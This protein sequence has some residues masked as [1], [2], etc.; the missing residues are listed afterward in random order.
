VINGRPS[1]I[2]TEP[3]AYRSAA[4]CVKEPVY[5]Q[6]QNKTNVKKLKVAINIH[7]M[8]LYKLQKDHRK[9]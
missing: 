9:L 4:D 5:A 2:N 6:F 3:I 8:R 7:L 1:K